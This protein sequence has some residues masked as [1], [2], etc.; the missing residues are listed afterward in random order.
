MKKKRNTCSDCREPYY[1]RNLIE[2]WIL[3]NPGQRIGWL[4]QTSKVCLTC[5]P[6][7]KAHRILDLAEVAF[8]KPKE[9][10]KAGK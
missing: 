1:R 8:E 6:V 2:M 10:V 3:R 7:S 4:K 5:L 9:L